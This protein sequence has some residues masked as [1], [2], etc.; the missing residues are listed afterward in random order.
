MKFHTWKRLLS[1]ALRKLVF[2]FYISKYRKVTE[3]GYTRISHKIIL[4]SHN[5]YM[6][7]AIQNQRF[8]SVL[9]FIFS[10]EG[11]Q[12]FAAQSFQGLRSQNL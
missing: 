8:D 6:A 4:T 3:E 7:K 11:V 10:F 12:S 1:L 9:F 2:S 5:P